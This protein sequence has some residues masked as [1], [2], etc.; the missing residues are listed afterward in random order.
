[1][2]E[3]QINSVVN[4][5]TPATVPDAFQ[6]PEVRSAV[7][8]FINTMNNLLRS[9]EQ[10][11]GIT[12]KDITLWNSLL[13]SDT[14]LRHQAGRLYVVA[15]ETINNGHFIN[16]HNNAG[17]LNVR[18]AQG[19]AGAV[20]PAHGFCSTNG[21]LIAGQ[22]GEVILSQGLLAI[23]GVLPGQAVYLSTVAGT[24]Q[25]TPLTGAGQLEQYLGVGVATDLVYIDIAT[26]PYIQH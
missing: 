9:I 4:L 14:L 11:T 24:A 6:D 7:E 22:R 2:P 18:K 23:S 10:Y 21:G 8:L 19:T 20:R 3:S 15:S 17:V 25:S 5:N 12:Q 26:G 16:L 13:P 1:M